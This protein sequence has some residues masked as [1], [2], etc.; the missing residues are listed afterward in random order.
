MKGLTEQI[1][2]KQSRGDRTPYV[3]ALDFGHSLVELD[4]FPS[5][6]CVV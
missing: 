1:V 5:L 2:V 3:S 6:K 4:N